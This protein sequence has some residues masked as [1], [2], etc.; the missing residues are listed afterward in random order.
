M[1]FLKNTTKQP[2][3]IAFFSAIAVIS[4]CLY[5]LNIPIYYELAVLI[6]VAF[7]CTYL[8]RKLMPI[9]YLI[10]FSIFY[11]L[12]VPIIYA[13]YPGYDSFIPRLTMSGL[14]GLL[15]SLLFYL[16]I[17]ILYSYLVFFL[18]NKITLRLL[19]KPLAS[20]SFIKKAKIIGLLA[21][22]VVSVFSLFNIMPK[23]NVLQRIS[24]MNFSRSGHKSFLMPDAKVL[25]AGGFSAAGECDSWEGDCSGLGEEVDT[26]ELFNPNTNRFNVLL[27]DTRLK[28]ITSKDQHKSQI[29]QISPNKLLLFDQKT[30]A[31]L[32]YDYY[33][34]TLSPIDS[35]K[36]PNYADFRGKTTALKELQGNSSAHIPP[37]EPIKNEAD[38]KCDAENSIYD[39]K[40]KRF[41]FNGKKLNKE[42]SSEIKL[43]DG[44]IL[45]TG[46]HCFYPDFLD[47]DV[48][49]YKAAEIYIP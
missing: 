3:I 31:K 6:I 16:F 5:G 33:K 32:I 39:S 4:M 41:F 2:Y 40:F 15:F 1:N 30:N 27:R 25:I 9:E 8:S 18:I 13:I 28:T 36:Y 23:H 48:L 45:S 43:K 7:L 21:F 20:L 24:N 29:I 10:V 14:G 35:S 12:F 22:L 11:A 26:I 19:E 17:R 44:R 46:G 38:T 42:N 34:N 37:F 47:L 49:T